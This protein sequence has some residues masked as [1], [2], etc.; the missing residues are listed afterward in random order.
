[1]S[2]NSVH[3]YLVATTLLGEGSFCGHCLLNGVHDWDVRND[4]SHIFRSNVA[5]TIEIIAK[6]R[7]FINGF[8]YMVSGEEGLSCIIVVLVDIVTSF[9]SGSA[10]VVKVGLVSII[11]SWS[12]H[13]TCESIIHMFSFYLNYT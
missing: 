9:S 6:G 10:E 2:L 3:E 11:K 13:G 1:M 12:S 8:T 5:I 7:L 4:K